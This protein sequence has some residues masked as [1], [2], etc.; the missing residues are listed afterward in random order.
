MDDQSTGGTTAPVEANEAFLSGP[1][2]SGEASVFVQKLFG[3]MFVWLASMVV[4]GSTLNL[5]ANKSGTCGPLCKYAIVTGVIS[6]LVTSLLLVGHWLTWSTK[7]D[8]SSW[9]TSN[10]EM[11]FMGG[12]VV[13]WGAGVGGLSAVSAPRDTVAN[14]KGFAPI[15]H[16]SGVGLF[17]GWLAFFGSI[18]TT[19][20]AYHAAKE[21]SRA[22]N[23]APQFPY[24][25]PEEEEHFANF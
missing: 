16:A 2:L 13:W 5:V 12:L 1:P 23:F 17:F 24:G 18:Y 7:N 9:F 11:R 21:E 8:R 20:K 25:A 10:A 6:I 4:F 19:F 3:E 22:F 14:L 15:A